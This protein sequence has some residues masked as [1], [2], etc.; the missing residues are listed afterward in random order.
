MIH[1]SPP[2]RITRRPI[3]ITSAALHT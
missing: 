2:E 1:V 3:V